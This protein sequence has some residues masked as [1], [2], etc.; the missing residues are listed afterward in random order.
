M[1]IAFVALA[2]WAAIL[3]LAVIPAIRD[4]RALSSRP[5]IDIGSHFT[6]YANDP[7]KG[8]AEMLQGGRRPETEG[9]LHAAI[10]GARIEERTRSKTSAKDDVLKRV[11]L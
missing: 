2:I 5:P 4:L 7:W 9:N 6:A 3:L 10:F 1:F 11:P 8:V